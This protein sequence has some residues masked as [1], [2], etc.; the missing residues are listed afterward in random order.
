MQTERWASPW[1]VLGE[2]GRDV[3]SVVVAGGDELAAFSEHAGVLGGAG[4]E[5]SLDGFGE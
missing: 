2:E 5:R 3:G 1:G 4:G